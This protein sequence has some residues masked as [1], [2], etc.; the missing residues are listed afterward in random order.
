MGA[1]MLAWTAGEIY[2]WVGAPASGELPVPS[3]ADAGY[4]ALYPA[5]FLAVVLLL[6]S[7]VHEVRLSLLL[8]G[9]TVGLA[10]ASV[11]AA[12]VAGPI[13]DATTGGTSRPP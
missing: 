2:Y 6:R 7:Q 9:L 12:L 10:V 13:L 5:A 1:G 8:D 11:A 3:L 4:L